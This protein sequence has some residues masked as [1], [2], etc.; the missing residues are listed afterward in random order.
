MEFLKN[1][2]TKIIIFLLGRRIFSCGN[3]SEVGR[4]W[5]MNTVGP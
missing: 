1:K 4:S 2:G 5:G 3:E